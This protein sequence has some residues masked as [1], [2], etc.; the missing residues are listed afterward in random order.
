ML[1]F[2]EEE[3][4]QMK[5][6]LEEK[7]IQMPA[8]GKIGGILANEL[9]DNEA[10]LHAAIVA[11]NEAIDQ[12]DAQNT[13]GTLQNPAARLV[14][15]NP[16]YAEEYQSILSSAKD[17]KCEQMLKRESDESERDMYDKLLTQ[18]EIQGHINNVNCKFP[19]KTREMTVVALHIA[20]VPEYFSPSTH[21]CQIS[22]SILI[23]NN[24]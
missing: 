2:S 10:A 12:G 15:M 6:N 3:V 11:I 24:L 21:T 18:A 8:F 20:R 14:D 7:N 4:N 5:D 13:L 19:L 9:S 17:T 23:L 1:L 16:S 22:L